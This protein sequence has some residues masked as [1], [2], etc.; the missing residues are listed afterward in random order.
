M[1]NNSASLVPKTRICLPRRVLRFTRRNACQQSQDTVPCMGVAK[2]IVTTQN[3]LDQS[4]S[5]RSGRSIPITPALL[6]PLLTA[7]T[8]RGRLPEPGI[9]VQEH[10]CGIEGAANLEQAAQQPA[11]QP[12]TVVALRIQFDMVRGSKCL[13]HISGACCGKQCCADSLHCGNGQRSIRP[14]VCQVGRG[15]VENSRSSFLPYQAVLYLQEA[16]GRDVSANLVCRHHMYC[17]RYPMQ[18][19]ACWHVSHI[20]RGF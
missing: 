9:G 18:D 19:T 4:L 1:P 2:R 17:R 11:Q 5:F 8:S 15:A 14:R 6:L 3:R 7:A 10:L 16:S 20:S 13:C 12:W